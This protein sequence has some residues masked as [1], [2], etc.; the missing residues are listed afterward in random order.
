M[1]PKSRYSLRS[2]TFLNSKTVE[3]YL[4]SQ[5]MLNK[6]IRIPLGMS[7]SQFTK[8]V[9]NLMNEKT[10]MSMKTA[11]EIVSKTGSYN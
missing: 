1:P 4:R 10:D 11:C 3:M 5:Q 9:V 8:K 2:G 6:G 7:T